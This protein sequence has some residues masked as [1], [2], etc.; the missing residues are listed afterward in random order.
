M[1]GKTSIGLATWHVKMLLLFS[2][3]AQLL[4]PEPRMVGCLCHLHDQLG[5]KHFE[6][7]MAHYS[8]STISLPIIVYPPTLTPPLTSSISQSRITLDRLLSLSQ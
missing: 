6:W 4:N 2:S 3:I 8:R 1:R 7:P 5:N